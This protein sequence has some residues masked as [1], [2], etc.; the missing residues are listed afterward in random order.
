[1]EITGY[2]TLSSDGI[3]V[4]SNPYL[5]EIE[6]W[7]EKKL[8]HY[9]KKVADRML[10][11]YVSILLGGLISYAIYLI[12]FSI[13]AAMFTNLYNLIS[14]SFA[15]Q[16][17]CLAI[18][19]VIVFIIVFLFGKKSMVK[20][21]SSCHGEIGHKGNP[22]MKHLIAHIIISAVLCIVC[23]VAAILL[24]NDKVESSMGLLV[25]ESYMY[26]PAIIA[27]LA[28]FIGTLIA[29]NNMTKCP[30]CGRF[31]TIYKLKSSEDFGERKD[32]QHKEYE[33]KSERVGT[34]TIK[35]TYTDGSTSTRSEGIY[36]SVR[37]TK[38]YED[39]S[40]L[41][42]YVYLCRECSYEEE[43]VE[44]KKWKTLKERYRG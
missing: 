24:F 36:E 43:T 27:P 38:V 40:N 35:T 10:S 33:H 41:S 21:V 8:P 20:F 3:S 17:V 1:M 16:W 28:Y 26:L 23:T 37:Y 25:L 29:R 19:Y 13:T 2:K 11:G 31:N 5:Q 15:A 12:F 30:I 6:V 44:E 22:F 4:T 9:K 39:F 7:D 32:G 14:K 42:K 18:F 34:K